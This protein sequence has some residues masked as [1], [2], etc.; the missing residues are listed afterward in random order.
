MSTARRGRR[1]I[2]RFALLAAAAWFGLA[3]SPVRAQTDATERA[4]RDEMARTMAKLQLAK[5]EKPYFISYRVVES[6]GVAASASFGSLISSSQQPRGR[7]LSVQ[8]RIGDYSFD[9]TN[10]SAIG[11]FGG[12]D[13]SALTGG[14]QLPQDDNYTELRRQIW[15][16]TDAAYKQALEQIAGKRAALQNVTQTEPMPDFSKE[17]PLTL[18]DERPRVELSRADAEALVRELSATFRA[19]PNAY[20]CTVSLSV[21]NARSLYF[22]SEGTF[23][24]HSIPRIEV[25]ATEQTQATDGMPLADSITLLA[26]SMDALPSRPE[27]VARIRDMASRLESLRSAPLLSRYNGP[28]LFE[29][30]AAAELFSELFAPALIAHRESVG[31]NSQ[32]EALMASMMSRGGNSSFQ[33]KI[34]SRVLPE[35]LGVSD[36]ATLTEFAGARM[37]GGYQADNDGVRSRE[38]VLISGGILKTLLNGRTPA[39]GVPQSTG[40]QRG[41]VAPSNIIVTA[42]KSLTADEM[43]QELLRQ[44]NKRGLPFGIIVRKVGVPAAANPSDIFAGVMAMVGNSTGGQGGRGKSV[45]LAYEIFPDGHEQLAR[46]AELTGASADSFK[47]ILA[48]SKDEAVYSAPFGSNAFSDLAASFMESSGY[49]GAGLG[50]PIVTYVVPSLLFE[51]MTFS[52]PPQELPKLPYTSPP[53]LGR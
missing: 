24:V 2:R 37:L 22:N 48:A 47:D 41:G 8:L 42:E 43:K 23:Y 34:G 50:G 46:G 45:E 39:Q 4:M 1:V 29:K 36:N 27:M 30:D 28:V 35:W 53:S 51:D 13:M 21:R 19:L 15:L 3:A 20:S 9:N 25:H 40:N 18:T 52:R 10:F 26:H 17:T 12:F 44:I 49:S 31:G 7:T 5:L 14:D 38:T 32:M 6:D 33:D 11:S 16:A